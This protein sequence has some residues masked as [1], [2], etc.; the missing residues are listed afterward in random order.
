MVTAVTNHVYRSAAESP[1]IVQIKMVGTG[2]AGVVEGS[3]K[4][5]VAVTELPVIIVSAGEAITVEEGASAQLRG[6]FN[7]PAG[8]TN[9]RYRWSF[10][11]GSA[12]EEGA[13]DEGNTVEVGHK[14]LRLRN[15]PYVA[16]LTVT[17][18]SQAGAV[19]ASSAVNVIVVEGKG[20]VVGGYNL[21]GNTRDA[22]RLFSVLIREVVTAGIWVVIFSPLW[23]GLLAAAFVLNRLSARWRPKPEPPEPAGP[24]E[25]PESEEPTGAQEAPNQEKGPAA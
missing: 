23:G 24:E 16:T 18:D 25:A 6:T 8:V 13:L 19:E 20:W 11:D 7:R 14:Y 21:K 5:V 3:D 10:G 15:Q 12:P 22:I 9:M 1:Y 17:G 2:E 4:I